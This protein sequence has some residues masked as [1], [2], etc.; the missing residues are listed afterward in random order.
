MVKGTAVWFVFSGEQPAGGEDPGGS[1]GIGEGRQDGDDTIKGDLH[2][3]DMGSRLL[4]YFFGGVGWISRALVF[5][6]C[7]ITVYG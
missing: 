2:P 3:A 7:T 4:L 1:A 6:C 5:T